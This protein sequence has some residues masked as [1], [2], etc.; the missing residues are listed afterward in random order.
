[1][2]KVN[3][4]NMEFFMK[5]YNYFHDSN[6][7]NLNYDIYEEKVEVLIEVYW[8]IQEKGHYERSKENVKL[9][10]QN[11][12]ECEIKQCNSWDF[13]NKAYMK[14]MNFED[15]GEMICFA[16]D[17]NKDLF[18]VVCEKVQFEEMNK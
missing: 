9:V 17:E 5:K 18:Y 16:S 3:K 2:N 6:F 11:V 14:L 10:F 4:E 8:K 12:K 7:I 15:W 1:M 13:I